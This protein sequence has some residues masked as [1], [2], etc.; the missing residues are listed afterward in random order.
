MKYTLRM[1]V[2]TPTNN[3]TFIIKESSYDELTEM[4][5]NLVRLYS[6]SVTHECL[7]KFEY[8]KHTEEGNKHYMTCYTPESLKLSRID[9]VIFE[10]MNTNIS[11]E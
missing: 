8:I 5:D 7:F 11:G 6:D 1:I 3:E 4:R 9:F 2:R 10:H